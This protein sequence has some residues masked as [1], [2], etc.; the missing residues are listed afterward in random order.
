M[1]SRLVPLVL[2]FLL[3]SS[4]CRAE[5]V[6][7]YGYPIADPLEATVIGTPPEYQAELPEDIPIRTREV[8]VLPGREV[9]EIFWYTANLRYSVS[10]QPGPAP[11]V[12][13]IP[14]TGAN[15]DSGKSLILQRALY[16][17]GLHV[18]SLPSPLHPNFIVSASSS[19][20]PGLLAQ[21]AEDIYRLMEHVRSQLQDEIA[22]TGYDLVGYSLGGT[23]AAFVARLDE[24]RRS[25]EFD[26]VLLINPPVSLE[27]S[28]KVLDRLF[29]EHI[30]TIADFNA[31]FDRLMRVLSEFYSPAEPVLLSDDLVYD[32]YRHRPLPDSTL[33]ALIGAA[34]RLTSINLIFTSDVMA[35]VGVL[36]A[37]AQ[38]LA[39]TDSLTPYFKAAMELSFEDY[40]RRVIYPYYVEVSPGTTF[41]QLLQQESLRAI[42]AFLRDT[43]KIGLMHNADDIVVSPDDIG[44]LEAIFGERARIYP[45]GGHNG[46]LAYRD[47]IAYLVRFF[48]SR[49]GH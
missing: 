20:R 19:R 21:D 24:M 44:F 43:Q 9:P 1:S 3:A 39:I 18:V 6:R 2:C 37:P 7:D 8:R 38:R 16:Q 26:R 14:G 28:A 25:F 4:P 30:R 13:I 47:N 15:F 42:G 49:D 34:F 46:N 17:V 11:L 35:H 32:I 22:I 36:V 33:E 27:E 41:E 23:N 5:I 31:L 12:F 45:R 40:A 29:E 48:S 10:A